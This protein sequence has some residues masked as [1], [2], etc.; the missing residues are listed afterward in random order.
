MIPQQMFMNAN[1]KLSDICIL[2]LA[3]MY[4]NAIILSMIIIYAPF[5]EIE[6]YYYPSTY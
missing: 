3:L 5:S 2:S 6:M 4:M 1:K